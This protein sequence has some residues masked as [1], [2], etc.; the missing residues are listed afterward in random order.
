MFQA[1]L[2]LVCLSTKHANGREGT[3]WCC[4]DA[5]NGR[6][7]ITLMMM[8]MMMMKEPKRIRTQLTQFN[9]ELEVC[10]EGL[11]EGAKPPALS[12]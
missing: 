2:G 5:Y 6:I 11:G 3:R 7:P 4:D 12:R 9:A 1:W 10:G 8:M